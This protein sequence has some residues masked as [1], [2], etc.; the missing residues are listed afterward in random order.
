MRRGI[1]IGFFGLAFLFFLLAWQGRKALEDNEGLVSVQLAGQFPDAVQAQQVMEKEKTLENP[2]N[3]LFWGSLGWQQLT[4][5]SL[6]RTVRTFCVG[7]YGD[8][9]L[10]DS[11]IHTLSVEDTFGCVL[12][13]QTARELF[14]TTQAVG[15]KVQL[16]EKEYTIRQVLRTR[17]REA[18]FSAGK[19]MQM[20]WVNLKKADFAD[21]KKAA[22]EFLIRY[23]YQGEIVSGDFLIGFDKGI[24][25]AAGCLYWFWMAWA[26]GSWLEKRGWP[27]KK[28]W[29]KGIFA[30]VCLAGAGVLLW[31]LKPG[32]SWIP[33]SWSDFSYWGD[34]IREQKENF[35]WFLQTEKPFWEMERLWKFAQ[36]TLFVLLSLLC[37]GA[38]RWTWRHLR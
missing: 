38:G 23:G 13:E 4:S 5:P 26:G 12:D 25:L 18:L 3:C 30:A 2:E 7:V 11:R 33:S 32:T 31:S 19:E 15:L 9:N 35:Y 6:G 37:A 20:N 29:K 8:G 21:A 17:G 10:Y 36:N 28:G 16:G 14:G 22:E 24:L 1:Q 34:L 27:V